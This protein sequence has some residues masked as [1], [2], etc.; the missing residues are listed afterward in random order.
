MIEGGFDYLEPSDIFR[1]LFPPPFDRFKRAIVMHPE[2]FLKFCEFILQDPRLES[3]MQS[4]PLIFNSDFNSSD[5]ISS[6]LRFDKMTELLYWWYNIM[7][8]NKN[9]CESMES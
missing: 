3:L 7:S 1:I 8:K 9:N 6:S 2:Q 4:F 5:H